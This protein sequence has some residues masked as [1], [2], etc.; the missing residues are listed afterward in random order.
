MAHERNTGAM[1]E[2]LKK[3]SPNRDAICQLMSRT[4]FRRRVSIL[5]D[6]S[7]RSVQSITEEYPVLKKAV[8]VSCGIC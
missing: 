2:L 8:Y 6:P 4:F 5:D 1:K 3:P 7:P